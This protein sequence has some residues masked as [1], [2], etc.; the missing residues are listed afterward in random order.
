[1]A[2]N[3]TALCRIPRLWR[4]RQGSRPARLPRGRRAPMGSRHQRVPSR[5]FPSRLAW[6]LPR[7]VWAR[8]VASPRVRSFCALYRTSELRE[9]GEPFD[10]EKGEDVNCR[11]NERLIERGRTLLGVPSYVLGRWLCHMGAMTPVPQVHRGCRR[12]SGDRPLLRPWHLGDRRPQGH[13]RGEGHQQVPEDYRQGGGKLPGCQVK[14]AREVLGRAAE[15]RA[16]EPVP[17]S[18]GTSRPGPRL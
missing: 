11:I 4:V 16:S 1:V 8:H 3:E 12:R 2:A 13:Q 5:P 15:G 17:S 10:T 6:M 7:A 14:G 18:R 9:L